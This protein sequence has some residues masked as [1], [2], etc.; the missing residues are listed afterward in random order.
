MDILQKEL[1][2]LAHRVEQQRIENRR[3][4]QLQTDRL[5]Q[6]KELNGLVETLTKKLKDKQNQNLSATQRLQQLEDLMDA[7]EKISN[8]VA[9]EN[10]RINGIAYRGMVQLKSFQDEAQTLSV[11]N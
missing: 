5:T 1:Q 2:G 3:N 6:I 4:I 11:C 9:K 8:Q 7:E 10:E